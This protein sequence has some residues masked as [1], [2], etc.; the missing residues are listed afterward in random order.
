MM[1]P[2]SA[3]WLAAR[4]G[5]LTASR[6][7]PIVKRL[8]NGGLSA[9]RERLMLEV[10]AERL[11]GQPVS[12]PVT[13]AMQWGL[14]HEPMAL[15][16]Y[17]MRSGKLLGP[18]RFVEHPRIAGFA[19]TPDAFSAGDAV[20]EVKCPTTTTHLAYFEQREVPADYRPQIL[21]QLACTGRTSAV[22]LS[23]DPRPLDWRLRLLV[24][25]WTPEPAEIAAIEAAAESF[26]AEL[27]SREAALIKEVS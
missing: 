18:S 26:L 12:V 7:A 20:V 2:G 10:M 13:A 16:E 4:C 21:A 27:A 24:V 17:E 11:T 5:K 23:F 6:C 25:H 8:R 14:D 3:E 1:T 22:F 15:A 19:A 9:E